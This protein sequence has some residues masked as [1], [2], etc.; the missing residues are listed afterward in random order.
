MGLILDARSSFSFESIAYG[1]AGALLLKT[2]T[3]TLSLLSWEESVPVEM[4]VVS[5]ALSKELD[6]NM[7]K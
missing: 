4:R 1:K 6:S 7:F 3:Y 5:E 2:G